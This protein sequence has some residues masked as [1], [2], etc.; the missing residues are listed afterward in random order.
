LGITTPEVIA[1]Q[2][3]LE[4]LRRDQRSKKK[5]I[6]ALTE[7]TKQWLCIACFWRYREN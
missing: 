5:E 7:G 6:E 1:K 4:Q 2:Y 3:E